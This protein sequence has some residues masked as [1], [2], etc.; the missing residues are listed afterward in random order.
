ML[1]PSRIL[2]MSAIRSSRPTMFS[3]ASW[4]PGF[5]FISSECF[6]SY[7]IRH[8][9]RTSI[10]KCY[11]VVPHYCRNAGDAGKCRPKAAQSQPTG[12]GLVEGIVGNGWQ[13]DDRS[14]RS[15]WAVL[16]SD[17]LTLW[18]LRWWEL[19]VRRT[20]RCAA[21]ARPWRHADTALPKSPL[22]RKRTWRGRRS[23]SPVQVRAW[24]GS[25]WSLLIGLRSSR[26]WAGAAGSW[27]SA[28]TSSRGAFCRL[29]CR[30][31]AVRRAGVRFGRYRVTEK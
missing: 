21:S 10:L 3:A 29:Q 14:F 5:G 7:N 9:R 18:T 8:Y 22:T 2:H 15:F 20:W 26:R 24:R 28:D 30:G 27:G 31:A 11:L 6:I 16:A 12:T 13:G 25:R 19:N 1:R 17:T 4:P 23:A